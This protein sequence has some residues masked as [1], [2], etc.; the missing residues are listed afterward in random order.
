[1]RKF[2]GRTNVEVVCLITYIAPTV[3]GRRGEWLWRRPGS[4]L[5]DGWARIG[6]GA[7]VAGRPGWGQAVGDVCHP[8]RCKPLVFGDSAVCVERVSATVCALRSGSQPGRWEQASARTLSQR[9]GVRR[10]RGG[11]GRVSTRC[12]IRRAGPKRWIGVCCRDSLR[13][14][15][16]GRWDARNQGEEHERND[17]RSTA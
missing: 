1:M 9:P 2:R 3:F 17:A 5:G 8:P 4:G 15:G 13:T 7:A 11:N 16:A 6:H 10:I 12:G 14:A